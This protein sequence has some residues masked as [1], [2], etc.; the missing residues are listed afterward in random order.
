MSYTKELIEQLADEVINWTRDFVNKISPTMKVVIGI[1]GGKDSSVVAAI[2]K[3]AIGVDRIIAV[4]M[5]CGK[6]I[7]IADSN[8]VI[9]ELD[10]V[11]HYCINIGSSYYELCS[12]FR[13]QTKKEL[14]DTFT[15]NTPARLRM[16]TL[17]GVAAIFG[18]LV[19]NTCNRSEDVVG[20]STKFGDH[21]GDFAPIN[22]LTTEEV[23][24]IGDY[25]GLPYELTH[26]VPA[27]GMSLNDDGSL[28]G[29]EIKLGFTYHEVN[30]IIRNNIHSEH[31]DKIVDMWKKNYHKFNLNLP[32][33]I[34][35]NLNDY[36]NK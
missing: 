18:G 3:E 25:L 24:A 29:D 14:P 22:H 21:A 5:P 19:V 35:Q 2:L 36:F 9:K 11:N 16:T 32:C 13:N 6:Q 17:Y 15:T 10:L 7:D 27:D 33:Y 31:Y 28:K 26:K 23:I 12:E 1:S 8:K 20:Y 4:Q 34:P 30:E